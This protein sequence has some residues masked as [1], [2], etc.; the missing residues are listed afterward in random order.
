MIALV[1]TEG[2]GIAFTLRL[3]SLRQNLLEERSAEWRQIVKVHKKN[4]EKNKIT[5]AVVRAYLKSLLW[6][7]KSS[8]APYYYNMDSGIFWV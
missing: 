6:Y 4:I 1:I 2:V 7:E 5:Q 8:T 3:A